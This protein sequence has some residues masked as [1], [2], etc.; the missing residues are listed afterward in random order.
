MT[1]TVQV[2]RVYIKATPER[3]WEAITK[4]E[5]TQKYGYTGLVDFDLKVG[6][7]HRTRPTQAFI[8]AGMTGDLVDGEVLEVDPPR[9]LVI[10]WKLLVGIDGMETEPYTTLTYDIEETKTAG[11]RLT[12]THDLT[13]APLTAEMVGGV[14]ENINA[15]PGENAGGGWA[16]VLSDLKSLLETGEILVP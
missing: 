11:T 9:K 7:K 1:N 4:P 15:G 6:G 2:H 12:I 5:W 8:D 13:G 14:H 16:W 10:T 3:I